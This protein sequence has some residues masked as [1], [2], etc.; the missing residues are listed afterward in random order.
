MDITNTSFIKEVDAILKN[1]EYGRMYEYDVYVHV[2]RESKVYKAVKLES[3]DIVRDY[4]NNFSDQ[5]IIKALFTGGVYADHIFPY[6]DAL[7]VTLVKRPLWG[8]WA[9]KDT[10]KENWTEKFTAVLTNKASPT[11]KQAKEYTSTEVLDQAN[12]ISLEFSLISKTAEELNMIICGGVFR[13]MTTD[14]AVKTVL[15]NEACQAGNDQS[16]IVKG[17]DMIPASNLQPRDHI[18][19]PHGTKLI[20]LPNYIQKKCGGIYNA[21]IGYYLQERMWYLYP[22][23]DLTRMDTTDRVITFI[24]IPAGVLPHVEKTFRYNGNQ[25]IALANSDISLD[26]AVKDVQRN[27]GNAVNFT[28]PKEMM[29]S[30]YS[31]GGNKVVF[32]KN[33]TN[34][35]AATDTRFDDKTFMPVSNA[36]ITDNAMAE[37]SKN[38]KLKAHN[39]VVELVWERSEPDKILPGTMCKIYYVEQGVVKKLEGIIGKA[40]HYTSQVGK[41]LSQAQYVNCTYV[42]VF[43]DT[44]KLVNTNSEKTAR[45]A[46]NNTPLTKPSHTGNRASSKPTRSSRSVSTKSRKATQVRSSG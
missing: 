46:N 2:N 29:H 42:S 14:V 5:I 27:A 45:E 7:D 16:V 43:V 31:Q 24:N 10:K 3:I 26:N 22:A 13:A 38:A 40:H 35:E 41:G 6:S 9:T 8:S 15:T 20:D 4:V 37:F 30:M 33:K 11:V 34:T 1:G 19:V 21:D 12:I 25:I 23:Y 17:V 39:G 18:V 44:N 32:D 36:P 28:S